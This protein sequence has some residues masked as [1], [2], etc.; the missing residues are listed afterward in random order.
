MYDPNWSAISKFLET[1]RL[2]LYRKWYKIKLYDEYLT[3]IK[4]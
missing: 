2:E 4:S 1:F 3:L